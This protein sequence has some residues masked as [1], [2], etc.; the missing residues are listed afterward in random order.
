MTALR[1]DDRVSRQGA[2]R[3]RVVPNSAPKPHGPV[4]RPGRPH[5]RESGL[6][7]VLTPASADSAVSARWTI[8]PGARPIVAGSRRS[9]RTSHYRAQERVARADDV[10][11]GRAVALALTMIGMLVTFALGI[12]LY[13]ALGFGLQAGDVV[14]VVSGDT[15]WNIATAMGVDVPTAQVVQDIAELN[16]LDSPSIA[17]G[18][19]L[20]L[21]A[22]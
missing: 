21:P 18:T 15:L 4:V 22:Y 12:F 3:L 1:L 17:A 19:E 9:E 20:V 5:S 16:A 10:Q 8:R 2:P 14:T 6:H 7:A 11:F 13:A